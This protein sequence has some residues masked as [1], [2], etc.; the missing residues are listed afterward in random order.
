MSSELPKRDERGGGGA[1]PA[2]AANDSLLGRLTVAHSFEWMSAVGLAV[3]LVV[4]VI[5]IKTQSPFFFTS[6][7]FVNVGRAAAGTGVDRRRDDV[8]ARLRRAR[9]L[10]RGRCSHSGGIAAAKCLN[11]GTS[12]GVAIAAG[13]GVGLA[14]GAVNGLL[15][16]GL[17]V[18]ALIGTIG[19]QFAF[20]GLAYIWTNGA[21][22]NAFGYSGF[23]YLGQGKVGAIYFST[24]LLIVVFVVLGFVL[25]ETRYGSQ[26]YAIGGSRVAAK[27]VGIKTTRVRA[28]V[29]VLSGVAAALGGLI[30]ASANGSASPQA[31][32]GDEL[33]I[34]S[35]VIIGGTALVGGRG[36]PRRHVPRRDVP[37]P[38][39]RT[40]WTWSGSR[41]SGRSSSRAS[42]S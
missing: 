30:V 24:I 18:N 29:Y 28:S 2:A 33:L 27:R 40:G 39:C 14:A 10:G 11:A 15:I 31:G 9:P 42:C 20:R 13:L 12:A 8:R 25:G 7:N 32:T 36:E 38:C 37:R 34:I 16:V 1:A 22:L 4:L 35:A 41:P 26:I 19:T 23:A 5:V 21:S 3:A 17:G 6:G